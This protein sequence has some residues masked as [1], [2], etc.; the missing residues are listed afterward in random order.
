MINGEIISI[1]GLEITDD[2][3]SVRDIAGFFWIKSALVMNNKDP[4]NDRLSISRYN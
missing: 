1:L 3:F 4:Y 2:L